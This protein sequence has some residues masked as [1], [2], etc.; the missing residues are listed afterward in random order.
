MYHK[1]ALNRS[2]LSFIHLPFG[3]LCMRSLIH[4][5]NMR[6]FSSLYAAFVKKKMH[7]KTINCWKVAMKNHA[8][9]L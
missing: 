7:A 8:T 6:Y 5:L 4:N 2:V 3:E 9:R 1:Y